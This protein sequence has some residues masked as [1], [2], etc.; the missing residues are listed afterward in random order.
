MFTFTE[1]GL[2]GAKVTNTETGETVWAGN[3]D[4]MYGWKRDLV[5]GKATWAEFVGVMH[6][7]GHGVTKQEQPA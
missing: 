4:A 7:I 6:S 2:Y 1:T 3:A 5:Q